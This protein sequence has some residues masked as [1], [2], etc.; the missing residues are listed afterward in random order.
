MMMMMIRKIEN[1]I[2]GKHYV[3]VSHRN[4]VSSHW[5]SITQL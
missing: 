1:T 2:M 3:K 4:I 5:N